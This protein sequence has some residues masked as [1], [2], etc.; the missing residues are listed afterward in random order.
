ML[1]AL[2]TVKRGPLLVCPRKPCAVQ[3]P[4]LVVA[5]V[6]GANDERMAHLM[7]AMNRLLDRH[8]QSRRRHLAWHTPAIV[9]VWPQVRQG[10]FGIQ[11]HTLAECCWQP[12]IASS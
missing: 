2:L 11:L 12:R 1:S 10:S 9:P 8:P 4:T 5:G 7:R 6:A 3:T